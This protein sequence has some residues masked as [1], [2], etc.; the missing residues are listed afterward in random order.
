MV[1]TS[2]DMTA[3]RPGGASPVFGLYGVID[4]D[5]TTVSELLRKGA[6]MRQIPFDI[7][8]AL[9]AGG[10][11][12]QKE[13]LERVAGLE[14]LEFVGA[15]GFDDWWNTALSLMNPS[16]PLAAARELVTDKAALYTRLQANGVCAPRFI[17]GDLSLLFLKEAVRDLGPRPVLK[18]TTGAAS[19]GVYR[20]R[21]DLSPEENLGLY[22]QTLRLAKVDSS[23]RIV[24]AEYLDPLEVS[25]DV[26]VIDAAVHQAVVHEKRTASSTPP[27]VDRVMVSPPVHS[28][29]VESIPA[30]ED[31]LHL[32][33]A[34][35]GVKHAV[36]H[37]ELRLHRGAWHV[38]DIGLRPGA[39]L[40]SHSVQALTGVDPRLAHLRASVGL[41]ISP[42]HVIDRGARYD[43]TCIACCYASPSSVRSAVSVAR[44]GSL[45]HDLGEAGNVIGWHLN[46]SEIDDP[47]YLP[48]AGLSLGVGGSTPDEAMNDLHALISTHGLSTG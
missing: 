31:T 22:R 14:A 33:V 36:L 4:P 40:V 37:V 28:Q 23:I 26:L 11:V 30:L 8:T 2:Q 18:P 47:F 35:L 5:A 16:F 45:V 27:F 32:L 17:I 19:R 21:T 1:G 46:V 15:A 10:P 13:A 39:G 24:A 12:L 44:F 48:D 9:E 43:A 42:V 20:Y 25:V 6:V 29:I 34:A 3:E 38:M 41:P 7:L